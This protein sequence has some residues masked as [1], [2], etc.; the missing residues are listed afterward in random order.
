MFIT[1]PAN[2][3]VWTHHPDGGYWQ[4]DTGSGP[5]TEPPAVAEQAAAPKLVHP[6]KH[7]DSMLSNHPV[8]HLPIMLGH[9]Q[10][11]RTAVHHLHTLESIVPTETS[12]IHMT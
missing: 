1:R 10:S 9:I 11:S 7:P 6:K 2:K 3:K 5:A 8:N 4:L 12:A